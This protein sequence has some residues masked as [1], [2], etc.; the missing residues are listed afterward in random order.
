MSTAMY[1]MPTSC[2]SDDAKSQIKR[3]SEETRSLDHLIVDNPL[4]FRVCC[5]C[6]ARRRKRVDTAK[7]NGT[8]NHHETHSS[9]VTIDQIEFTQTS[10][11]A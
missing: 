10:P 9:D 1:I 11:I 5:C 2:F 4:I 8:A 7:Q 3:N 6:V